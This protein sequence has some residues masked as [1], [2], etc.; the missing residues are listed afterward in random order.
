MPYGPQRECR[1]GRSVLRSRRGQASPQLG[2]DFELGELPTRA[3]TTPAQAAR[4]RAALVSGIL[5]RDVDADASL[6]ASSVPRHF[7]A[8]DGFYVVGQNVALL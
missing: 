8:A 1:R 6:P 5:A 2:F 4:G 7:A 3:D